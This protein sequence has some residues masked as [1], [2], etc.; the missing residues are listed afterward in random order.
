M[1]GAGDRR[2]VVGTERRPPMLGSVIVACDPA[3]EERAPVE[4]ALAVARD[5]GAPVIAV[6]VLD[7]DEARGRHADP[8]LRRDAEATLARLCEDLGVDT[9]LAVDVSVPHAIHVVAED[10][11][12]DMIVVGATDRGP[13]G[14]VLPGSTADRLIHGANRVVA[15][16]PPGW[17]ERPLESIAVGFVDTPEGRAA[18][19]TAHRIALATGAALRCVSV[20]HPITG[21]DTMTSAELRPERL[22]TLRGRADGD[23][24]ATALDALRALGGEGEVEIHVDDPADV[25]LKVSR[26]VDL[27]VCG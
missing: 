14:R 24:Y 23:A 7:A 10:E 19:R 18:L 26:H 27:L 2:S 13:L 17:T 1:A 21:L 6:A 16:V 11:R 22:A 3:R 4:F 15:L 5:R 20:V 8:A 9:R 25:L 12:A